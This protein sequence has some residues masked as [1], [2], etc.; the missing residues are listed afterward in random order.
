MLRENL[1]LF[2]AIFLQTNKINKSRPSNYL[3]TKQK[4]K[5]E[6]LLSAEIKQIKLFLLRS[7]D[8]EN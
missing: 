3:R 5:P 6:I 1:I 2:K 4:E 7:L 8:E